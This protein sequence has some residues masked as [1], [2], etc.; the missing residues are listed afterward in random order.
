MLAA[1]ER[2]DAG[3]TLNEVKTEAKEEKARISAAKQANKIKEK[4]DRAAAIANREQKALFKGII[5]QIW[6]HWLQI[7]S[8]I[9]QK[10]R[11]FSNSF[12]AFFSL[13]FIFVFGSKT[14]C[15]TW[16]KSAEGGTAE[17]H[18]DS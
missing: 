7:H 16:S 9:V 14:H 12:I 6:T 17:T 2:A 4:A 5:L 13:F 3:A 18:P 1:L 15:H 11:I 10:S 8:I